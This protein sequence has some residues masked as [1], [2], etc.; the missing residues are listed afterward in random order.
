MKHKRICYLLLGALS[1]SLLGCGKTTYV[2]E[3]PD[4]R[5]VGLEEEE[6]EAIMEFQEEAGITELQEEYEQYMK[7]EY[8]EE[9][10][11]EIQE[12]VVQQESSNSLEDDIKRLISKAYGNALVGT[13]EVKGVKYEFV[14]DEK[15]C[16]VFARYILQDEI[17]ELEEEL[18]Y[19]GITFPVTTFRGTEFDIETDTFTFPSHV[20]QV[21]SLENI[22]AN[23]YVFPDTVEFITLEKL[24]EGDFEKDFTVSFPEGLE[25]YSTQEWYYTF[26]H[27]SGLKCMTIPEG[28][29]VL[30][31]TFYGCSSLEE[32][33]LPESLETIGEDTFN[34]CDSLKSIV[35]PTNVKR[36][37]RNAFAWSDNLSSIVL[38]DGLEYL[39]I[40]VFEGC[41]NLTELII[42]DSVTECSG[43]WVSMQALE[44]LV[45][46][47]DAQPINAQ[48]GDD[49]YRFRNMPSLERIVF[50]NTITDLDVNF[51]DNVKTIEV[52]EDLVDYLQKKYP[53]IEV[54]ARE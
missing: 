24:F 29:K 28:A 25:C 2:A 27:Q 20:K 51:P 14:C 54:K 18:E 30:D 44:L 34:G 4:G 43:D 42:P 23:E 3:M 6:A 50:P 17:Y 31:N 40:S 26:G 37:E 15:N 48:Y 52:P 12:E 49:I 16:E 5:I 53:D 10:Q 8:E 13:T 21:Y 47:K 19:E 35:I 33:T 46:P 9:M 1:L 38:P 32:V 7:E 36:I 45:F 11:E 41:N 39:G 22:T